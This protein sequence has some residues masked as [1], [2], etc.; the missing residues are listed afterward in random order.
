MLQGVL[1]VFVPTV[2]M[3][4]EWVKVFRD[5]FGDKQVEGSWGADPKRRDKIL[6]FRT[7]KIRIFVSTSILERGVTING[8]QVIV[9]YAHHELYDVRTLVQMA[10]R[11]GR[12][13]QCP[14]G[15]ALFLA[16]KKAEPMRAA[17]DWIKEQNA[18]AREGGF[19]DV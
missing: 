17:L 2:A 9:L 5:M 4:R 19:L 7:G 18:L 12:T 11:T 6:G 14:T 13:A 3:V 16:P 1:L 15:R 8:V 10:G